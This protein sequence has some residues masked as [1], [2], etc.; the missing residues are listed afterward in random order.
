MKYG[1]VNGFRP[2]IRINKFH[3]KAPYRGVLL[4]VVALTG[5]NGL[6]LIMYVVV[7]SKNN[8]MMMILICSIWIHQ[9]WNTS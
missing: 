7:E 6:F 9:V 4:L 3:P 5:N 1:F 8:D 2:F